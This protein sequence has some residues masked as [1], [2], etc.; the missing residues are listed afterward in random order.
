VN[1]PGF[2][3][4][5]FLEGLSSGAIG[6]MYGV[7][8][9][10]VRRRLQALREKILD[11]TRELLSRSLGADEREIDSLIDFVRSRVDLDL[12]AVLRSSRPR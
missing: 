12:G 5:T 7:D 9:S 4:L 3:S 1:R 2:L 8:G 11:R 10:T 6:K